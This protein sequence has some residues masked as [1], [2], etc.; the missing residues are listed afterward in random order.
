MPNGWNFHTYKDHI[1]EWRWRL[2]SSNGR[3]VADSG[4]GY[5]SLSA[6]R[7]AAERV[8]DHAGGATID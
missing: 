2:I 4:E 5:S 6:C 1:G 3:T 8:K 7:D